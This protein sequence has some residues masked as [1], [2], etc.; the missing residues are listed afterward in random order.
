MPPES[1]G[2]TAK[3]LAHD[4]PTPTKLANAIRRA[5]YTRRSP[6]SIGGRGGHK[7][8]HHFC[9]LGPEVELLVNFSMTD[10]V[11]PQARPGTEHARIT[12]LARVSEWDGDVEMFAPQ[13]VQIRGG[14]VDLTFGPNR[15][16]FDG[17]VYRIVV[18]LTERPITI[19][20]E[21]RPLTMPG[22]APNIPLPDGPPLH[23]VIV[24]R[25]LANGRV[26]VGGR[27]YRFENVAA[28]HDHNWGHFL[29][30]H[31]FSWIWGFSHPIGH[32]VPWSM[33]F[34]RLAN[35]TRNHTLAQGLFLWKRAFNHR[36]FLDDDLELRM[37]VGFLSPK[38]V[39]KIPR[40]MTLLS[41]GSATDV[42][43][44]VEMRAQGDGDWLC[45]RFEAQDLAQVVIPS[46]TGLDVTIINEVTGRS[47]MEGEIRG[48]KIS[49]EGRAICEFLGT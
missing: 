38:R 7:E 9:I 36:V 23:W 34:V 47:S 12:V 5:D 26:T 19:D 3:M 1:V 13:D 32:D 6:F 25:L 42:P 31:A 41:P 4:D 8:W 22:H 48:E 37:D 2:C 43:R 33:A 27:A 20:I 39:L 28:Y 49:V 40:V 44:W 10:D 45:Y 15:L 46:D 18:S 24:P 30:G 17:E 21:L 14:R 35:R 29:W 16:F 11:R